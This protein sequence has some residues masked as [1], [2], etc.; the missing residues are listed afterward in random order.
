[1][2][3]R[4][5]KDDIHFNSLLEVHFIFLTL[6]KA[7]HLFEHLIF[8]NSSHVKTVVVGGH[9]N[10]RVHA[11]QARWNGDF[12][13]FWR[14]DL[15]LTVFKRVQEV[16]EGVAGLGN[17][18]L[19]SLPEALH[20]TSIVD[21]GTLRQVRLSMSALAKLDFPLLGRC[22]GDLALAEQSRWGVISAF[23]VEFANSL[24]GRFLDRICY[25]GHISCRC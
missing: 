25:R 8:S 4:I 11:D 14:V 2:D 3:D 18:R 24:L 20:I 12:F 22:V 13:E 15:G 10:L 6:E 23:N 9:R 19:L 21:G 5:G 16:E 7:W 17:R 1:M